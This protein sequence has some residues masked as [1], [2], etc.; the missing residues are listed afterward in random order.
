[1]AKIGVFDSGIG[2][3]TLASEL[4]KRLKNHSIIYFGDTAHFPYGEK[5]QTSI[6]SYSIKICNLLLEKG[7][8]LILI[9]CMEIEYRA[10]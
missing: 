6:Q 5:S 10:C 8:D 7:C 4:N 1:M 9:G 2:G 3:L